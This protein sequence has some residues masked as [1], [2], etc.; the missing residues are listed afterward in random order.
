MN[1][2]KSKILLLP[3]V[4]NLPP[5]SDPIVAPKIADEPIIVL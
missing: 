1:I 2:I 5:V 3:Y 4:I